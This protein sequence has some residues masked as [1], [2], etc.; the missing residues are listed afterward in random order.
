MTPA[1][2]AI[3][4]THNSE[5]VL[6]LCLKGLSEQRGCDLSIIIVDSGST[7]RTYLHELAGD[8]PF[9]LIEAGN[10]G[11]GQ[12]NNLGYAESRDADQYVV[13][14]NPD[15]ILPEGY[16]VTAH[17]IAVNNSGAAVI[18]G[19]LKGYDPYEDRPTGL[20]DST[21]VFRNWYGRWYDRDQGEEVNGIRR[22]SADIPAVCGALIVCPKNVL[23]DFGNTIFDPD[24]FLYKEDIELSIRLRKRGWK[25]HFSPELVA[26]HCRGWQRDRAAIPK[27]IRL[28]ASKN[29]ILLYRKHPSPYIGW[30]V[31]KYLLVRLF[32]I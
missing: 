20:I 7:D 6:P 13:F 4:V 27:D 19:T 5:D 15:T 1:I 23:V 29:E 14:L 32:N 25:L 16:L 11:Y 26:Y 28:M 8:F 31:F 10:V 21:G 18:S 17:R 2:T 12:A 9:T 30:A 3:V 24:F 22:E